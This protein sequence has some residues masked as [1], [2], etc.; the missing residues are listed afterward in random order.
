[1]EGKKVEKVCLKRF[2]R[3]QEK[4]TR[5]MFGQKM[6]EGVSLKVDYSKEKS[7]VSIRSVSYLK[8]RRVGRADKSYRR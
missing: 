7:S 2:G 1:M 8:I 5:R 4:K 6:W 3:Q